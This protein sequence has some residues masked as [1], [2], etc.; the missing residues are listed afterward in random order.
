MICQ[1]RFLFKCY[2]ANFCVQGW[3]NSQQVH[4][5]KNFPPVKIC[6][7]Y[8][9]VIHGRISML[10]FLCFKYVHTCYA[11]HFRYYFRTKVNKQSIIIIIIKF[12]ILANWQKLL[13]YILPYKLSEWIYSITKS[14]VSLIYKLILTYHYGFITKCPTLFTVF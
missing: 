5:F 12:N 14:L 1:S 6:T 3:F 13:K 8:S 11:I 10:I 2:Y 7:L 9:V 4:S